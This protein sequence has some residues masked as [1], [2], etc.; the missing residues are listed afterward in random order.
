MNKEL[1]QKAFE[2]RAKGNTYPAVGKKLKVSASQ[3]RL[4][5][6]INEIMQSR[7]I[8]WTDGLNPKI[9]WAL[10]NAGY[11]SKDEV[12]DALDVDPQTVHNY[13]GMGVI[14]IKQLEAW[15]HSPEVQDCLIT[16]GNSNALV[17]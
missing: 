6:S 7:Q 2:L 9:A 15:L 3:A 11:K 12:M 16:T 8:L 17:D 1:C 5:V 13:H 10:R 4:M 14:G